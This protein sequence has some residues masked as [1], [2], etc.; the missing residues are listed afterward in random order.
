MKPKLETKLDKRGALALILV[1]GIIAFSYALG[2]SV[3]FVSGSSSSSAKCKNCKG[4]VYIVREN[5]TLSAI[6]VS[7]V[8]TVDDIIKASEEAGCPIENRNLIRVGQE[9]CIPKK[10]NLKE[11][12]KDLTIGTITGTIQEFFQDKLKEAFSSGE[13]GQKAG[14]SETGKL[15]KFFKSHPALGALV[16][17][18]IG[19]SLAELVLRLTANER[20]YIF[21]SLER[22]A[23][24]GFSTAIITPILTKLLPFTGFWPMVGISF[25]SAY[26]INFLF[27]YQNFSKDIRRRK[28][29]E[30]QR[31]RTWMHRVSVSHIWKSM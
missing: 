19:I 3:G 18:V 29:R 1:V 26:F 12:I 17:I 6:A 7:R 8:T 30:V 28:L 10:G 16:A 21:A 24:V 4:E 2:S 13:G 11:L 27:N 31:A 14:E 23:G 25:L 5:D 22:A 15:M 20:N 9:I